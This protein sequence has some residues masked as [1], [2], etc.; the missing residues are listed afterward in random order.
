MWKVVK[1]VIQ[2]L[3]PLAVNN[4]LFIIVFFQSIDYECTFE[5]TCLS[6]N[7]HVQQEH[8]TCLSPNKLSTRQWSNGRAQAK[9]RRLPSRVRRVQCREILSNF[10]ASLKTKNYKLDIKSQVFFFTLFDT[11]PPKVQIFSPKNHLF[12]PILRKKY[13]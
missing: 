10:Q 11:F 5:L 3:K 2:E 12:F 6:L 13:P 9:G 8:C 4:L 7:P 1:S